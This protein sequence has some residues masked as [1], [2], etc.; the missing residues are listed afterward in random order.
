MNRILAASLF[1]IGLL[2][3]KKSTPQIEPTDK[4]AANRSVADQEAYLF[5]NEV[6]TSSRK[7]DK[8]IYSNEV[9]GSWKFVCSRVLQPKQYCYTY[10]TAYSGR[11]IVINFKTD[12]TY[13]YT[14]SDPYFQNGQHKTSGGGKL[15]SLFVS[16]YNNSDLEFSIP[17]PNGDKMRI[18]FHS[19]AYLDSYF[20][21]L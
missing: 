7:M 18:G 15:D 12:F 21:K 8:N 17:A 2:G 10:Y 3:C 9:I 1:I 13:T 5:I 20:K 16:N 11:N 6:G 14:S 19:E 4:C